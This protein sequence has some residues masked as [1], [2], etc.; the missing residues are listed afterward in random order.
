MDDL[1][2]R[3]VAIDALRNAENHAFNT[4][5]K[6]LVHAHKIIAKLPSVMPQPKMGRWIIKDGKEQG[7]DIGGVKTW[8]IQIVC[9]K[10]GFI[11]TAIEGH[12]GHYKYCPN[13]GQPKI[14]ETEK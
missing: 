2:S 5:Y 3:E 8:Y 10:C 14:Q 7:Y 1:I 12:T 4:Y 13:C 9:D 6:G 11:K